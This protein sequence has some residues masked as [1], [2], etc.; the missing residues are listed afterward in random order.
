MDVAGWKD[1]WRRVSGRGAYPHQ[2]AALLLL[3]LRRVVLSP[4]TLIAHLDLRRT[5]RVL[6]I[7]PGP[8]FF[9][10][11][12]AKAVPE[13]RLEL[14]DLQR[15]MLEKARRRVQRAGVPNVGYTQ[16]TAAALPFRSHS[17]DV[18]FLVA[19]LGEVPD[20]AACLRAIAG[21]LRADGQLIVAELPGDPD[22]LS[23]DQLRRL[24]AG[25]GLACLGSAR[26]A[27][28]VITRFRRSASTAG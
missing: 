1:V 17:F 15:E 21:V 8:G 23:V 11:E 7:G 19:V 20:P 18:V 27:R 22:V 12:V 9:S 5:S 26:A 10:I 13:G 3:P 25:T 14:V 24:S 6:E 16:A 28:S 4:R 2:L